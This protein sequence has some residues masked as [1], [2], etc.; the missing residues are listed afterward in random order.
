MSTVAL[1]EDTFA[2]GIAD[3]VVLVDVWGSGCIPCRQFHPIFEDAAQ[4]HPDATFATLFA[5]DNLNLVGALRVN[6]VPTVLVFRDGVLVYR[7]CGLIKGA[8]LDE[9]VAQVSALDMDEVRRGLH[10]D[11]R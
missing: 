3:G 9:L 4:R 7:H 6:T 2:Q 10:Q 11:G 8:A 5:D 1:T